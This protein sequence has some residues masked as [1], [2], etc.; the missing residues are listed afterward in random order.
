MNTTNRPATPLPWI[1]NKKD[2]ICSAKDFYDVAKFVR[3]AGAQDA[4]YAAHACNAYPKLMDALREIAK[5][6]DAAKYTKAGEPES[7][8]G[9]AREV[10]KLA[11]SVLAEFEE[12]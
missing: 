3:Y 10:N 12:G 11:W 6:T 4:A 1:V 7:F 2:E 5:W 9:E 8:G